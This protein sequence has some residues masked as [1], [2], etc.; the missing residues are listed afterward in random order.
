MRKRGIKIFEPK[1][2]NDEFIEWEYLVRGYES[3]HRILIEPL[4]RDFKRY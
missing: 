3:V 4:G 1:V 2:I